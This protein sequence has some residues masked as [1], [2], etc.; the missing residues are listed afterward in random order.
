MRTAPNPAGRSNRAGATS[1][2]FSTY[3]RLAGV[4]AA[5]DPDGA[6]HRTAQRV[7]A[8]TSSL[9]LAALIPPCRLTGTPLAPRLIPPSRATAPWETHLAQSGG[10]QR[11]DTAK[12][13][14]DENPPGRV[15]QLLID[16]QFQLAARN[17]VLPEYGLL[18][19]RRVRVRRARSVTVRTRGKPGVG[20]A[21]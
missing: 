9:S 21:T 18:Q 10:R 6:G 20:G 8:E 13:A 12:F 19:M 7:S 3:D 14:A 5:A 4:L 16:A 11:R 1:L 2:C 17:S 15:G